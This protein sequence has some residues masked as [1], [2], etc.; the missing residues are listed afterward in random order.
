MF[1][2]PLVSTSMKITFM[3]LAEELGKRGHEVVIF[4]P[5]SHKDKLKNVEVAVVDSK[6]DELQINISKTFLE[7]GASSTPPIFDL[8]DAAIETNDNL[9]GHPRM[10]QL[11]SDPE[12]KFDILMVSP[13]FASES[14]Y[15][16]AHKFNASLVMYFTGQASISFL[17]HALGMPHNP[18]FV[19]FLMLQ[20]NHPMTFFQRVVNTIATLF[21]QYVV[22]D[23]YVLSR[24]EALL[25]KHFPGEAR[26]SLLQMEKD[27]RLI[28]HY[29]HPL[30]MDGNRPV[31][32]NYQ[33][34][35]M[36][37]CRPPKKLPENLQAFMDSGS[38]HG[39]IYVSFGSVLK[40]SQ[41]SEDKRKLLLSVFSKL[42]QKV[43]WKWE[44]EVLNDINIKFQSSN[45]S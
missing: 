39:V 11:L 20:Y 25:D 15:Y 35:G 45:L 41:M 6:F 1:Y 26:R 32:P 33:Y 44:T 10:K 16:L 2:M 36:M 7:T 5:M 14:G 3:P 12:T 31:A 42:K 23:Y 27:V 8:L 13:F 40:A 29:G 38:E 18:A 30:I 37:N 28:I 19:P 4:M 43:I 24:G 9:L 17:D 21:F 22:R 34:I